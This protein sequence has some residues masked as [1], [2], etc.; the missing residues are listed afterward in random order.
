MGDGVASIFQ[1]LNGEVN[2]FKTFYILN[3]TKKQT[4]AP[5]ITVSHTYLYI[6]YFFSCRYVHMLINY[7]LIKFYVKVTKYYQNDAAVI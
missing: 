3:R 1:N 6:I 2:F 7:N 4:D 5:F